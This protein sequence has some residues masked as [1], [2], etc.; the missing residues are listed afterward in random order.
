MDTIF[1]PEQWQGLV[2]ALSGVFIAVLTAAV[3][4]LGRAAQGWLNANKNDANVQFLLRLATIGVQA[5]EQV[6]GG[7]NGDAKKAYAI[8]FIQAELDKRKIPVD[9]GSIEAAVESAVLAEFNYPAAVTPA[10]PPTETV[11]VSEATSTTS[12]G[13]VV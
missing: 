7:E 12:D 10:E 13:D 5:A 1:T 2:T 11:V 9:I 6:Y 4:F 8:E 3:G